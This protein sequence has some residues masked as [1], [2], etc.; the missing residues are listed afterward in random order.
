MKHPILTDRP[1]SQDGLDFQPYI[2]SLAELIIDPATS[3]PLT[4][5]V[6]GRWGSGKTSLMQMIQVIST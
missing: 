2:D 6:F 1:A 3:T 4:I 5:G